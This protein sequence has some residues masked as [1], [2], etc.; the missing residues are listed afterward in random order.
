MSLRDLRPEWDRVEVLCDCLTRAREGHDAD[1]NA[2]ARLAALQAAVEACRANGRGWTGL[3]LTP[4]EFDVLACVLAAEAEPRLG[5]RFAALQPSGDPYPSL[6]LIQDLLALPA[7]DAG[8]LH[9]AIAPL[10]RARLLERDGESLHAPLKPTPA[11]TAR[12]LERPANTQAP[13]GAVAVPTL[14]GWDE[15]VLPD[16]RIVALHEFVEHIR[17]RPTV[18]GRWGAR[19]AGGPVALFAG[20]SGTGKTFAA[21][22]LAA[23][24]GWPLYR[25]DLGLLVSKYIGETEKNLNRLFDAADGRPL[26]LQF[27]EADSLFGR[28]GEVRDARDRYANLAVSHLLSRLEAHDGP[29]VLTTNLRANLDPAFARRFQLV[30]DFPRPDGQA[31]AHLWRLALPPR[32]PLHP[33]VDLDTVGGAVPLSGGGIRNAA[34]H[35]AVLA[36]A[37]DRPIG[38]ADIALAAWR[39]L[40]K[41]GRELR[42]AALGPLREHLPHPRL[43][44]A[45]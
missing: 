7:E 39:E 35:A 36:A 38:L 13:P 28:R 11:A 5:V 14:A 6:A 43:E 21:G 18:V 8:P 31:R 2:V 17:Q 42:P 20:P 25:V 45:A 16:D 37:S 34:L 9:A 22:V 4:L 19:P 27:D 1:P 12:L 23:E 41:D 30:L 24:L 26:M 29:C 33:A 15:L 44:L 32:A 3:D 40:A 10:R